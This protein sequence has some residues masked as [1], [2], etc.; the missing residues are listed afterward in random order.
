[1][2][3]F[4]ELRLRRDRPRAGLDGR[5][6]R[7]EGA[8]TG[9]PARSWSRSTRA[10][11]A[12]SRSTICWAT[13]RK[14]R[15]AAGL[16]AAHQLRASWSQ[17]M[18]AA[19]L[20]QV[21]PRAPGPRPARRWRR[22]SER[23]RPRRASISPATA[24]SSPAIAA[25][26]AAALVRRLARRAGRAAHR[27]ARRARPRQRGRGRGLDAA[28]NRPDVVVIAAAR[29]G[30]ILA[31]A[32]FPVDFLDDNLLHRAQ[33]DPRRPRGRRREAAV[34]RQ[35]LHLPARLPAADP[36]GLSAHRPARAHQR[37]VRARQ[38]RRH[39][40]VPGLSPPA[41][42]RLHQ[43]HADQ[44][45]R[46]RRQL[47]PRDQP[48]R[49]GPAPQA[50]RGQAGGCPFG[51]GLGH[52]ARRGASSSMSTTSPTPASSCCAA[53]ADEAPINVGCGQDLTIAE[54]A[55][56]VARGRRLSGRARV[57]PHQARRHAAQAARRLPAD[58][59]RL[60]RA[61]PIARGPRLDLRLVRGERRPCPRHQHGSGRMSRRTLGAI[62]RDGGAP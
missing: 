58:R 52:A 4:V 35:L 38:D 2:R 49:P 37:V 51:P 30:G 29:V 57:R 26:S 39:Q 48:R 47:R 32:T 60:E 22:R 56:L 6:R 21:A 34:P 36:R 54:L 62:R 44:P 61:Y 9:A 12:R 28:R 7:G 53:T 1:M 25:W 10:T 50:A 23:A 13:P 42:L 3:E 27:R 59:P 46:A 43:R 24:S 41:R 15:G 20:E 11:S 40:A 14:A 19:D 45:L 33:P 16:A 31:N 5:G 8:S 17:E 18:V 55:G